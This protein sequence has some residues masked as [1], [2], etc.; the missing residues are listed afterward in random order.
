VR[1]ERAPAG[2]DVSL[3]IHD[4]STPAEE[5]TP[6]VEYAIREA[7]SAA[8]SGKRV[9]VGCMGGWGR[10]GLFLALLAKTCGVADP[11]GYVRSHYS[12]RAV[13]T[14]EQARYVDWFDVSALQ[15]WLF[16]RAWRERWY[17]TVFWW[18]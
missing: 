1:A 10:T 17:R 9:W 7:L 2:V 5:Q 18:A 6:D 15:Q 8:L 14:K 16:G 11:V 4:F 13:E 3:P 12:P